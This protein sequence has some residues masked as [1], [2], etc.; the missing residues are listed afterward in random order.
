MSNQNY[1]GKEGGGGDDI[2]QYGLEFPF[3]NMV[4]LLAAYW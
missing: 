1:F 2:S 4:K 3:I